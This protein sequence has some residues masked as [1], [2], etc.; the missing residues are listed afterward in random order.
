VYMLVIIRQLKSRREIN[1]IEN[2][3]LRMR[4]HRED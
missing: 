2:F 1:L 3:Q 4:N